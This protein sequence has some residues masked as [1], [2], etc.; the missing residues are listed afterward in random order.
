MEDELLQNIKRLEQE[1]SGTLEL[2]RK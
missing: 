2:V 1:L